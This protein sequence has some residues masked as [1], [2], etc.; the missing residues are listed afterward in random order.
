MIL[1][2]EDTEHIRKLVK[3][4][5]KNENID[6]EEAVTGEEAINKIQQGNKYE[7]ILM[8][9]ML[10]K[11]DGINTT[12]KIREITET[13][14][15]FLTALS[16]ER[17][18]IIAYEAGADGYITKPFS[19]EILKSIV[20]RYVFKSGIVK[21]YGDLEINK[22]SGK[23]LMNKK[24][25]YLTIKERD[26]LFYLEE[27]IGIVKTREQIISG[28]WGYDFTGTDRTVDKHL[29]RL[30]EKLGNC[31]KYLKTVKAIGYKFEE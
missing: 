14:I 6:V 25:I 16:D 31:S 29:T 19:K 5:L 26:I 20:I 11:I 18:Q 3:A 28:V 13:P 24:E 15:I 9:V 10:P 27:N 17:S 2:V 30:R 23:V 7:L 12:K 21:K 8:D 4:I 22:K 1:I